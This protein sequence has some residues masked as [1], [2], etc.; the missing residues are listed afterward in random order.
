MTTLGNSPFP[1][2]LLEE[3]VNDLYENAP[4]GYLSTLPD[5]TIIKVNATFLGW[6]GY[7]GEVLV[8]K[9][10][11]QDL[12]PVVGRIFYDTH[13]GPLLQMQ[14]FVKELAFEIIC[15]NG[16]R[17]PIL[18]NSNLKRDNAGAPLVIRT[19]LLDARGRRAYEDELRLAKRRAE[20]AEVAV[21]GL[22]ETLEQRVAERTRERDRIWRISQD[23]LVVASAKG[24]LLSWNPAFTRILGW[25]EQE[26]LP[27]PFSELVHPEQAQELADVMAKLASGQPVNR[28]RMRSRHKNGT[29]RWISWTLTPEEERLY[30]VGRDVTTDLEQAEIL[31][32]TEDALRQAQKMEAIGQLTGGIAHDFN[33]LLA[34]IVG[35]LQLIRLRRNQDQAADI[36]RYIDSAESIVKRAAALTHRLLAFSRRQTL[37]PKPTNVS[38]LVLSMVELIQRTVGPAIHVHTIV[39]DSIWNTLCDPNQL[40]NAL[41]NLSINARDAMP[42]GGK[43]LIKTSNSVFD[44]S[45]SIPRG[46]APGE[47]V[48]ISITDTGSGMSAEVAKRAF[49][50]FFTTKPASQGTGLGLSMI[51]GFVKQ[52]RGHIELHSVLGEGTTV[53]LHLPVYAGSIAQDDTEPS[54]IIAPHSPAR[55]TILL[56]DDEVALRSLLTEL[57]EEL[58]YR[59]IQAQDGPKALDILQSAETIDLLVS[60]VGLPGTMNGR[61]LADAARSHRPDL[62]VIFITGYAEHGAL[63]NGMLDPGMQVMTKPFELNEFAEK[64][65][66]AVQANHAQN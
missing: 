20:D 2:H 16:Q 54:S 36:S 66:V 35:N 65:A 56:V 59:V 1:A 61:Q 47:Y 25:S 50:P 5:G 39:A 48:T 3:D 27:M 13:F 10:R 41:L 31:R 62:P 24:Y 60:D 23:I 51:F 9:K 26:I 40:E 46:A 7:S 33:N 37:D 55:S 52:S 4:C 45:G 32:N 43:L 12:L 58:D 34:G 30:V 17:M 22:N 15:E 38:K 21:R 63:G 49:E 18:L 19:T 14:G 57:L 11:F 29:Y 53:K 28:F 6:T 64:V 42:E 8:G 44:A